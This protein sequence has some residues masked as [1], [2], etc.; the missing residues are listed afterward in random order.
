MR[1]N[2][3]AVIPALILLLF[4]GGCAL[5]PIPVWR[6]LPDYQSVQVIDDATHEV[7]TN[8]QISI[9]YYRNTN[10][11]LDFPVRMEN[12][13]V[14]Y[15]HPN[16]ITVSRLENGTFKVTMITK[17]AYIKPWGIGPLGT[18]IYDDYCVIISAF[19][20]GYDTV[21]VTYY[22]PHYTKSRRFSREHPGEEMHPARHYPERGP[23][24]NLKVFLKKHP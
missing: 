3:Q 17:T 5:I 23:E 10:W 9:R 4:T 6:T 11:I 19:A 15:H 22:P 7:L 14:E 16:E 20:E 18:C 13:I 1:K 12:K 21:S 8:A 24:G 2:I